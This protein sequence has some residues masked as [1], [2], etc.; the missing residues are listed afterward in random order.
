MAGRRGEA[1]SVSAIQ[2]DL[3][4]AIPPPHVRGSQTSAAAADEMRPHVAGQRARVLDYLREFGPASA[5]TLSAVLD[6]P[7]DSIRPRLVELRK[8]K[9]VEEQGE[10]ITRKGRRCVTYGAVA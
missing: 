1:A 2:S 3:W 10:G 7:G 4:S 6:L 9:L 5:E 8:L